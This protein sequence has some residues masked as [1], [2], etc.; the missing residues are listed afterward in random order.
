[1]EEFNSTVLTIKAKIQEMFFV[2]VRGSNSK[3]GWKKGTINTNVMYIFTGAENWFEHLMGIGDDVDSMALIPQV[4]EDKFVVK[5]LDLDEWMSFV[6]ERA[7]GIGEFTLKGRCHAG[8]NLLS[9]LKEQARKVKNRHNQTMNYIQTANI[10]AEKLQG[11]A[12][13]Y[14]GAPNV[15]KKIKA[16]QANFLNTVD[17]AVQA[18]REQI[19]KI[20]AIMFPKT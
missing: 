6:D 4:K 7:E 3:S 5:D 20:A 18:T 16:A 8:G 12:Q 19:Q 1:M 11:K 2:W 9:F 14:K 13:L 15:K 10:I 17:D